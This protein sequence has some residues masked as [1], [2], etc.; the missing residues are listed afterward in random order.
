LT[1]V[2]LCLPQGAPASEAPSLDVAHGLTQRGTR[3]ALDG[4]AAVAERLYREAIKEIRDFPAARMGLG[5]IALAREE[6]RTAFESYLAA[7]AGYE[8]LGAALIVVERERYEA[9]RAAIEELSRQEMALHEALGRA[10]KASRSD[11]LLRELRINRMQARQLEMVAP[12]EADGA[13]VILPA[14]LH[15]H[16]GNAL[17][18]LEDLASAVEAWRACVEQRPDAAVVHANLAVALHR[19]GQ[20]EAARASLAEAERLGARVHPSVRADLE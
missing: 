15:Y 12:L 17:F 8:R 20:D 18:V 16:L 7:R 10:R 4:N 19:L 5:H 9:A 2:L 13:G 14:E 6:P 1:A 11:E 3:A